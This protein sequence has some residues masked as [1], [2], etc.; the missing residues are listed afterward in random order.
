[1][2]CTRQALQKFDGMNELWNFPPLPWFSSL[3]DSSSIFLKCPLDFPKNLHLNDYIESRTLR[4]C[5]S[6]P[7]DYMTAHTIQVPL[8][9]LEFWRH[10]WG[11]LVWVARSAVCWPCSTCDL[12]PVGGKLTM[13]SIQGWNSCLS[14]S[15]YF[16]S[17][18]FFLLLLSLPLPPPPLAPF[19]LL[20][21]V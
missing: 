18:F 16:F 2:F 11:L 10:H 15:C 13:F 3:L 14:V 6:N 17:F 1:M 21:T 20:R 12:L 9:I 7:T 4:P 8:C 5:M 19:C